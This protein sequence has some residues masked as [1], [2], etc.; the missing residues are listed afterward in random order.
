M[1]RCHK[2]CVSSSTGAWEGE[3]G[4]EWE[5]F[6]YD[7]C[8]WERVPSGPVSGGREQWDIRAVLLRSRM[9]AGS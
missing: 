4:E 2:W 1:S 3:G 8:G 9:L 5:W 7:V 6:C